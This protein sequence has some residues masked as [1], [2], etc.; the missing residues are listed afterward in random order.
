MRGRKLRHTILN[1]ESYAAENISRESYSESYAA[2][3]T[4]RERKTLILTHIMPLKTHRS[5]SIAL[6]YDVFT[7]CV[8]RN[9][10]ANNAK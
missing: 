8:A 1:S 7:R 5:Y 6:V 3:N 9:S 10:E 2:E 4:S